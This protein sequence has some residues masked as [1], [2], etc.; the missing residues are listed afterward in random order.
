MFFLLVLLIFLGGNNMHTSLKFKDILRR[1]TEEL[2]R[3]ERFEKDL[4]RGLRDVGC[5]QGLNAS[6]VR[7]NIRMKKAALARKRRGRSS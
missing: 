4:L 7:S 2:R 5:G 6:L 1:P 3:K